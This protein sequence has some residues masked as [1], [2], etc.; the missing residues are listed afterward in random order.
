MGFRGQDY[1]F[2]SP[3]AAVRGLIERV[4]GV[5]GG[6]TVGRGVEHVSLVESNG[7]VLAQ[8][9]SSDRDSPAFDCSA[10][11]GYAVRVSEIRAAAAKARARG[12]GSVVL[13]VV[14]ES[15]IGTRPE[16]LVWSGD[17]DGAGA[18]AMRIA[19]GA[20][21][22]EGEF[23]ADGI[24]KREDVEERFEGEEELGGKV[25]AVRVGVDVLDRVV[26]GEYIR[27]RGENARAGEGVV[28]AGEVLTAA[29]IGALAAVGCARP[30]VYTRLRVA[31]V[32][33]GD[34]VVGV[35][36]QPG[37]FEI[38]NSNAV[39]I[40]AML[41]SQAWVEVVRVEHA[42]DDADLAGV[43]RRLVGGEVSAEAVIITGGVSMGHRDPVRGAV[44]AVGAEVVFHGL[45]Q[46]PGKPMLGAVY[47]GEG[48]RRVMM[49]GLPGNPVSAL[50][51]C[52]RVVMPVLA[53]MAG[54]GRVPVSMEA[55]RV[56][57]RGDDGQR[58]ALWWHRLV[59]MRM[60]EDGALCAELIENR[61]SGDLM[62]AARSDGFVELQ[63]R[64]EGA[65]LGGVGTL[66]A[67]YS[68]SVGS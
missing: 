43:L 37:A 66:V 60:G 42:K 32:T 61:G 5:A 3:E 23:G 45:P 49:M 59:M 30:V 41:S 15:R 6:G 14:G 19:T 46:K 1:V 11:D 10:M 2:D 65:V 27:R 24:I 56:V 25:K 28:G 39:A 13:K 16:G 17:S 26:V 62:G 53:V 29:S 12:E 8:A 22:P 21:V 48:G 36:D 64:V 47:G 63:P 31:L 4:G 18:V 7:R 57:L 44:E 68:W 52:R 51:T 20:A 9:V 34:E 33:T 40:A 38:R 55:K 35:D 67:Y 50:V 58:I 54:S